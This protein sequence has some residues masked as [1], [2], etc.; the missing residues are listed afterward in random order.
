MEEWRTIISGICFA[1]IL[2]GAIYLAYREFKDS[3]DSWPLD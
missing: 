1:L 3:K 2:C